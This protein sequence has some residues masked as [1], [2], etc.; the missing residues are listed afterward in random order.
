MYHFQKK[1]LSLVASLKLQWGNISALFVICILLAT[2]P[3]SIYAA[4]DTSELIMRNGKV[5]IVAPAS[6]PGPV[7][8][9]V[10]SLT[11]DFQKVMGFTP[12]VIGTPMKGTDIVNV[13]I[14]DGRTPFRSRQMPKGHEAHHVVA[15]PHEQAVYIEG[16]D[17]R[18]TIYAIY[19][20]SEHVLGVPPL[21]FYCSWQPAMRDAITIP[22][23]L[24]IRFKS[25]QVRFRAWFP[26]DTDLFQPWRKL[27]SAND[28]AWLETMLRLKMNTVEL[29]ATVAYPDYRLSDE[30][31]LVKKYGLIITSHHHVALNNN[32]MNWEGYWQKVRGMA[33]PDLS[34][35]N[36]QQMAEFWTYSI[37]TV[38]RN[39]AENIWQISFR[40]KGD[41]PFWAL[42]KDAPKS[43]QERAAVIN[44]MLRIQL[45]LIKK[46]TGEKHPYVRMTFYDELSD[47]LSAK[48]LNP[49]TGPNTIWTYVAARRDHYPNDDIVA[50]DPMLNM[51]LG[52]YMNLQFTSTGS[53]LAPA[54]G[55]WKMEFNYRYV[56]SRK[57]LYFSVVNAG[58]IREH[59]L[60]LAANAAM[61][62]DL[63]SYSTDSFLHNF[64]HQYFG[65]SYA[66]EAASI[67]GDYFNAYWQQRPADFPKLRRQYIFHDMRY[68]RVFD[69]IL[70]RFSN[71]SPNPLHDIGFERVTG[72]T[73]RLTGNDNV[74]TLLTAT[75]HTSSSFRNVRYRAEALYKLLP[76]ER[77]QFFYDNLLCYASFMEH[78]NNSL[79]SF[80]TAYKNQDTPLIRR[81]M[82]QVALAEMETARNSLLLTCHD[83][84]TQWYE[85]ERLW[86]FESKIGALKK[87]LH[88]Q[89]HI[90]E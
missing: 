43:E 44:R 28:Q 6:L 70:S 79:N 51:R 74:D 71:Y 73:F 14:G 66:T 19:T 75:A 38:M 76:P 82:L 56:N 52:Y 58:N 41:Q 7:M 89:P 55:P 48:M 61:M 25:P 29:E 65:E 34:L 35:A 40:G 77:R 46:Y 72:R 20:F 59:L 39:G 27:S 15:A 17:M 88:D 47:M 1:D 4:T 30:A 90:R 62:W 9:A 87:L 69:Q 37:K 5:A 3:T 54:E 64:C 67:Y 8:L 16:T 23:S 68:A 33:P 83:Q 80:L 60:S 53:H 45:S 18:G 78:L 50:I 86:G 13:I 22:H 36:I 63:G 2:C 31:M 84:F 81:E 11:R 49:P 12:K 10:K 21:W 85:G 32:F 42:F 26:N 57:P 24:H